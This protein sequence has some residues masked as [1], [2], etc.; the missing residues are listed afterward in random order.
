MDFTVVFHDFYIRGEPRLPSEGGTE[1]GQ[2]PDFRGFSPLEPSK[3]IRS[4]SESRDMEYTR[5]A[6]IVSVSAVSDEF[7]GCFS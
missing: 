6:S 5:A 7:Y 2:K 3:P 4:A 1:P